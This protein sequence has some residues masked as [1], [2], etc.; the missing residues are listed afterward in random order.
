VKIKNEEN[1]GKNPINAKNKK[2]GKQ[3]LFRVI[4]YFHGKE[5]TQWRKIQEN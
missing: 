5:R 4:L 3:K 2:E 1:V